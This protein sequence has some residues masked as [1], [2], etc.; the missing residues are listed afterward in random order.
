MHNVI[1]NVLKEGNQ[2]IDNVDKPEGYY[3]KRNSS[4]MKRQIPPYLNYMWKFKKKVKQ[5]K[6]NG[7]YEKQE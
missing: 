3:I 7:G 1:L 5:G 6:Q 2:V 4:D